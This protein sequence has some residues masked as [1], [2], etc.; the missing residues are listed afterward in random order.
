MK[1]AASRPRGCVAS[2]NSRLET[3][4]LSLGQ[5]LSGPE[6]GA[7]QRRSYRSHNHISASPKRHTAPSVWSAHETGSG[8]P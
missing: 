1:T 8:E 3:D 7:T 6:M 2:L 4:A 5:F